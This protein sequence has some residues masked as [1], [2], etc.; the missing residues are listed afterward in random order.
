MI[1]ELSQ[2]GRY[3]ARREKTE[4]GTPLDVAIRARLQCALSSD[5]SPVVVVAHS[6][7]SIVA[8]ETLLES[9][10][11]VELLVTLGSPL[12]I[13]GVVVDRLLQQPPTVPNN[14]ARWLNYWDRDDIVAARPILENS[15]RRNVSGVAP[16]SQRIDSDGIWVHTAIKYLSS[17]QVAGPI[18]EAL[19]TGRSTSED[20]HR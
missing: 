19:L 13:R 17:A 7:G 16:V 2:V 20:D 14:V 10:C 3:L 6:L 4:D 9:N 18:V 1:R 12:A 5:S 11:P 15:F 8:F